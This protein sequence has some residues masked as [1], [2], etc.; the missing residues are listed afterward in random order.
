VVRVDGAPLVFGL[1]GTG[2]GSL[3]QCTEEADIVTVEAQ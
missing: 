2:T 1:H 3:Y